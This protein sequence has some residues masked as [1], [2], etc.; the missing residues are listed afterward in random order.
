[1]SESKRLQ[2]FCAEQILDNFLRANCDRSREDPTVSLH[3]SFTFSTRHHKLFA[4]ILKYWSPSMTS[5]TQRCRTA[6][7]TPLD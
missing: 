4:S 5:W 2:R 1:M 7:S 6:E 3:A